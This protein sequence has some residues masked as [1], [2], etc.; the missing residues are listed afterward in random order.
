MP[1][2]VLQMQNHGSLGVMRS[3]GRLGIHVYGVHSMARPMASLSKY[4]LQ[5]F[6]LNLEENTPDESVE[7]LLN[8][9]RDIGSKPLLIATNDEAALFIAQNASALQDGFYFPHN[10]VPVIWSLYNKKVMH[11]L[12]KRLSIPTPETVFPE[13]REDVVEF[14]EKARFPVMLKASDNIQTARVA[15]KKM[16]IVRSKEELISEYNAMEDGSN[17]TLMLQEYIPGNDDSVWMFNGYFDQ[18]SE[19][20][21]GIT[22]RKIHQTPVYTGMTALGVCLPNPVVESL[23]KTLATAVGYKGILDI[24]YRYDA[25]DSTYKLLDVNPRLGATFRLFVSDNGMDVARAQ[26]LHFTGQPVPGGNIC[27]GRKW[28]LED[29]DLISCLRYYQDGVLS[30]GNW[31]KG[32]RGIRECA[33]Y[34]TDDIVPFLSVCSTFSMKPFRKIFRKSKALFKSAYESVVPNADATP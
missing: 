20:L 5:T 23:T 25:R 28:I 30:L 6:V 1:V 32:Y 31:L 13:C 10:P 19:C 3:L 17:P 14:C 34:A 16:V 8:V 7:G 15:G 4:C 18:N 29:A 11:F 27:I 26:Y 2:V 33:W 21:F 24:G 12:A 9:S 22:A